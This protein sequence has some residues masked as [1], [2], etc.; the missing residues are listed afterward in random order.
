MSILYPTSL[1][2]MRTMRSKQSNSDIS[3]SAK[4]KSHSLYKTLRQLTLGLSFTTMIFYIPRAI[5]SFTEIRDI[6]DPWVDIIRMVETL[7]F[8]T[9]GIVHL[10]TLHSVLPRQ[11]KS[12][13]ST[14]ANVNADIESDQVCS[15]VMGSDMIP[16]GIA[17]SFYFRRS[18][19]HG[20]RADCHASSPIVK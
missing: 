11:N 1:W 18:D 20:S 10:C 17:S 14:I 7:F 16:S 5:V 3:K 9:L 19:Y 6:S 8:P 4:P 15:P 13:D 12:H 2:Y